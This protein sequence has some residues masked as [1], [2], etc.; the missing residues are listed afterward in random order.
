MAMEPRVR[1]GYLRFVME[2]WRKPV[3]EATGSVLFRGALPPR[4]E[5]MDPLRAK[6]C[7]LHRDAD[8]P[9]LHWSLKASHPTWGDARIRCL[10]DSPPI[11]PAL[12]EHDP[13]LTD[14]EKARAQLGRS[15]VSIT[16]QGG[17]NVLRQRK[18][19]LRYLQAAG[20]DDAVAT[21]DHT[22]QTIWSDGA[23]ADELAHDADLDVL[24][25]FTIHHLPFWLHTHGL[26]ELGFFDFDVLEP[27]RDMTAGI[28][29][30]RALAFLIVEGKIERGGVPVDV[31]GG[32]PPA[33]LIDATRFRND[34]GSR[35]AE[36]KS[37]VDESH[38][39]G[40][41]VVAAPSKKRLFGLLGATLEP[42]PLLSERTI[43]DRPIQFSTDATELMA[44]RARAT[45]D[46]F[47]SLR[48]ELAEFEFPALV[49]LCYEHEHLWFSVEKCFDERVEATL[50]SEPW[51]DIGFRAGDRR[52][53]RLTRLTD[54]I[55]FTPAGPIS[56]RSSTPARVIR[57][58]EAEIRAL[59]LAAK[60]KRSR[61]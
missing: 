43:S 25:L 44:K 19:L 61:G 58:N 2:W 18:N 30:I 12:L 28:D 17:E 37:A 40:H 11:P 47:R 14:S 26:S 4:A 53:H 16:I 21:V 29:V 57:E 33:Q 3:V 59:M 7:S 54:W 31:V 1:R 20:G 52:K 22:S 38:L 10:R 24:G 39:E 41:A 13:R 34:V 48:E 50:E 35:F 46:V 36:W 32:V 23:L 49:K 8:A 55:I 60:A 27:S 5:D 51:A 56:P 9:N 42:W 6:G 45:W 15:S